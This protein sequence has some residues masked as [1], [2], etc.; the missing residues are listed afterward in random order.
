MPTLNSKH[1]MSHVALWIGI[2][3]GAPA[4]A[5]VIRPHIVL[6][7]DFMPVESKVTNMEFH[8]LEMRHDQLSSQLYQ[9]E[10]KKASER[11]E[12]HYV[13]IEKIKVKKA[14]VASKLQEVTR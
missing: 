10:R 8:I 13:R 5:W 3:G 4:A 6:A 7:E 9:L 2:I 11:D 1:V 12:L 14:F